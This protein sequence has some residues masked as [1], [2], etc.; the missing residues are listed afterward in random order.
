MVVQLAAT[1]MEAGR[2]LTHPCVPSDVGGST[3]GGR[4]HVLES[5][6]DVA[7]RISSS[8]SI[9]RA[10]HVFKKGILLFYNES[11]PLLSNDLSPARGVV[12]QSHYTRTYMQGKEHIATSCRQSPPW[13]DDM[14]SGNEN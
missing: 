6:I 12:D 14:E 13:N 8:R 5:R 4:G 3:D 9:L 1:E 10:N 11:P 7:I 2:S